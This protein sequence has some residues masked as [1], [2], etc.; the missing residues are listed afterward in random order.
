MSYIGDKRPDL[1]KA[2]EELLDREILLLIDMRWVREYPALVISFLLF[3]QYYSDVLYNQPE[4]SN[5][6]QRILLWLIE[7]S[8]LEQGPIAELRKEVY[9]ALAEI[10]C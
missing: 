8:R 7:L 9:D 2:L 6:L 3:Y 1:I 5:T 10:C 4:L